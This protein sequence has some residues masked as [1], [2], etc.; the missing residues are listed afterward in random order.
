MAVHRFLIC[1]QVLWCWPAAI[2]MPRAEAVVA[3]TVFK[4]TMEQHSWPNSKGLSRNVAGLAIM[5]SKAGKGA[6]RFQAPTRCRA[7]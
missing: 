6:E 5:P 1:F 3:K 2:C 4:S 7:G